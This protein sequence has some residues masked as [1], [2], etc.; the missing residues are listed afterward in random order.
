M[1]A[2]SKFLL[3]ELFHEISP[4]I[5]FHSKLIKPKTQYVHLQGILIADPDGS[6]WKDIIKYMTYVYILIYKL[7]NSFRQSFDKYM[8]FTIHLP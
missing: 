7:P 5:I 1:C 8:Y 2:H 6:K 3:V 4:F